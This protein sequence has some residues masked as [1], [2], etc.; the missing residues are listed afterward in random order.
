MV[1]YRQGSALHSRSWE[2]LASRNR[3]PDTW[4]AALF[5]VV[6]EIYDCHCS[7]G[8]PSRALALKLTRFAQNADGASEPSSPREKYIGYYMANSQQ[9]RLRPG[10]PS[11]R[12]QDSRVH[13]SLDC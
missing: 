1:E 12:P 4:R 6:G 10:A 3:M 13:E 11:R 5:H 8:A 2:I 9:T 7:I